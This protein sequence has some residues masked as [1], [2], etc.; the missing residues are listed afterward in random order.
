[1][2]GGGVKIKRPI[3]SSLLLMSI[4]LIGFFFI[5]GQKYIHISNS[6]NC[7]VK[8]KNIT[9]EKGY[10]VLITSEFSSTLDEFQI[11]EIRHFQAQQN[12]YFDLEI[13]EKPYRFFYDSYKQSLHPSGDSSTPDIGRMRLDAYTI[14]C[15]L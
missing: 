3:A 5:T 1:L 13:D 11:L 9:T 12:F 4:V 6:T 7:K 14:P 15:K 2:E 8:V 10:P